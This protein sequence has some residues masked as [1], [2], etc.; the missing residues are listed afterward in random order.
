IS[1]I[2]ETFQ[3]SNFKNSNFSRPILK[4]LCSFSQNETMTFLLDRECLNNCP[5]S[6]YGSESKECLPCHGSCSQCIGPRQTQCSSCPQQ[7]FYVEHLGICVEK[8]PSGYYSEN[9]LCLPCSAY[10]LECTSSERCLK[11]DHN[12]LLVNESCTDRCPDGMFRNQN[13]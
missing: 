13:R 6:T 1:S 11:C 7:S 8:C 3:N 4:V 2:S 12:L 10:C 5:E 9:G